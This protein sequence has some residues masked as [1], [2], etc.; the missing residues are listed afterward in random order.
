M[1]EKQ[2]NRD[3]Y[4]SHHQCWWDRKSEDICF[5]FLYF[6]WLSIFFF[7]L[8]SQ[9]AH[10]KCNN[11]AG[12]QVVFLLKGSCYC[13]CAGMDVSKCAVMR[14]QWVYQPGVSTTRSDRRRQ[15]PVWP[16]SACVFVL[17][18][19]W[20]ASGLSW[21]L[22]WLKG[23]RYK[24]KKTTTRNTTNK[25]CVCQINETNTNKTSKTFNTT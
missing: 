1:L 6:V 7:L 5:S 22:R 24:A 14:W 16:R 21:L 4:E 10:L 11:K 25:K 23:L 8:V 20:R 19:Q 17:G 3:I 9:E 13:T 12:F 18:E 2:C 15:R